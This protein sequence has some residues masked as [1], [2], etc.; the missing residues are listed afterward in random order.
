ML[1]DDIPNLF[2]N[3]ADSNETCTNDIPTVTDIP[4]SATNIPSFEDISTIPNVNA[5]SESSDSS[6]S[7]QPIMTFAYPNVADFSG[8]IPTQTA[9]RW[10][11]SI[12]IYDFPSPTSFLSFVDTKLTGS[13]AEWADENL[14]IHALLNKKNATQ[15]DKELFKERFLSRWQTTPPAILDN[16]QLQQWDGEPIV[17]FYKRV[18]AH[19]QQ[20]GAKDEINTVATGNTRANTYIL[21]Q[22]IHMF[23][24]GLK[25]VK[26][27]YELGKWAPRT[28][29]E[30]CQYAIRL[31]GWFAHTDINPR[32]REIQDTKPQRRE[33]Y[34]RNAQYSSYSQIPQS[35][36]ALTASDSPMP[37]RPC[38]FCGQKHWDRDCPRKPLPAAPSM[39]QVSTMPSS[40]LPPPINYPRTLQ[41]SQDARVSPGYA[42]SSRPNKTPNVSAIVNRYKDQNVLCFRCGEFGH[43]KDECAHPNPPAYMDIKPRIDAFIAEREARRKVREA[44]AASS[45]I[46]SSQV[47]ATPSRSITPFPPNDTYVPSA[48]LQVRNVTWAAPPVDPKAPAVDDDFFKRDPL[49]SLDIR[50]TVLTANA[51]SK[52]KGKIEKPGV[53]KSPRKVA[54]DKRA[55][56]EIVP[57]PPDDPQVQQESTT[58][59]A[60]PKN[61]ASDTPAKEVTSS[62]PGLQSN[63]PEVVMPD[64]TPTSN[65]SHKDLQTNPKPTHRR[66]SVSDPE[67][68]KG[69]AIATRRGRKPTLATIKGM[70]GKDKVDMADVLMTSN[71]NIPMLQFLQASPQ[72]RKEVSS[73]LTVPRSKRKSAKELFQTYDVTMHDP[74]LRTTTIHGSFFH[75]TFFRNSNFHWD[76]FRRVVYDYGADLNLVIPRTLEALKISKYSIKGTKYHSY[77]FKPVTG[78]PVELA[79]VVDI[80]MSVGGIETTTQFFVIPDRVAHT[81]NYSALLGLPHAYQVKGIFDVSSMTITMTDP[82]SGARVV[83]NGPHYKP[84]ERI[85][86][87]E[88][89]EADNTTDIESYYDG[90][91]D[92]VDEDEATEYD[93]VAESS[94]DIDEP[95]EEEE[96]HSDGNTILHARLCCVYEEEPPTFH[97]V[98]YYPLAQYTENFQDTEWA[99]VAQMLSDFQ[100]EWFDEETKTIEPCEI[101]FMVCSAPIEL[102]NHEGS[103]I[104]QPKGFPTE[105]RVQRR[106]EEDYEF[107]D[108]EYLLKW[109]EEVGVEI[110]KEVLQDDEWRLKILRLC[111]MWRNIGAESI[112]DMTIT[113]LVVVQPYFKGQP[114]PYACKFNKRLTPE[115]E[116]FFMDTIRKGLASGKYV[117]VF[118]EWNAPTVVAYKPAVMNLS[119]EVIA[120]MIKED[121]TKVFRLTHNYRFLNKQVVRPKSRL[122]LCTRVT[123]TLSHPR[124]IIYMLMDLK[125]AY[126]LFPIH[127]RYWH[128]FASTAPDGI[129]YAPT[130]MQQGFC[131]SPFHCAEGVAIA[132]GEIPPPDPE[133][134]LTGDNFRMYQDDGAGA[135]CTIQE[136]Y[137]F[138]HD[139]LFPRI[140]WAR[141]NV[142][143]HKVKLFM[144]RI[145]H[146]GLVFESGGI[147]HIDPARVEKITNYPVPQNASMVRSFVQACQICRPHIKN[148]SEM[149]RPL[150]RLTG[151]KVPFMW[152][153]NVENTSFNMLKSAVKEAVERHGFDNNLSTIL[154]ADG[155]DRCGGAVI[156]QVKPT[157]LEVVILYDS[158]VLSPA[159]ARY[160]T[161]KKELC[162]IIHMLKK[163][164]CYLGGI[165]PTIV[166]SDHQPLLGFQD[167][168]GR[169]AVEGI[170]ARW[171]EILEQSNVTWQ[172]LPGRKNRGA[173]A[174]SRTIFPDTLLER[175]I[176]DEDF[177]YH[178]RALQDTTEGPASNQVVLSRD[179]TTFNINDAEI[180][181]NDT[182]EAMQ[183]DVNS[184]QSLW[185]ALDPNVRDD[186]W[187]CD[188]I[189]Y[190]L[191][192]TVPENIRDIPSKSQAFKRQCR[193]FQIKD[194]HLY[195]KHKRGVVRCVSQKDVFD[196]L[197]K[198][199][200]FDGHYAIR[201][202]FARIGPVAWWPSRRDDIQQYVASCFECMSHGPV[203]KFE[204]L[205]PILTLQPFDM[206]GID[207]I[208]PL[209]KTP[210]GNV[211]VLHTIEYFSRASKAWATASAT[212]QVTVTLLTEFFSYYTKPI[213]VY[214]DNGTH[215]GRGVTKWLLDQGVVH[216]NSAS[217]TPKSTGMI[218]K[219]NHQLEE[220]I[221]RMAIHKP[222]EWDLHIDTATKDINHHP[223]ESL[224]FSPYEI[225]FGIHKRIPLDC[226]HAEI[227]EAIVKWSDCQEYYDNPK[228]IETAM[229]WRDETRDLVSE[230]DELR[231][232]KSKETYDAKLRGVP[233][234][235]E[236]GDLVMLYDPT[237]NASKFDI[238]WRGPFRIV[239]QVSISSYKIQHLRH[240]T[241]YPGTY[242]ADHL[243]IYMP[244]RED[245]RKESDQLVYKDVEDLPPP[246]LRARRAGRRGTAIAP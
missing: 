104:P 218:E 171:A 93:T 126:W 27:S 144:Y 196:V 102:N 91:E 202:T 175:D 208:G 34:S 178:A 110:G 241:P 142:A 167:S 246:T 234:K 238:S 145:K 123:D 129:Q 9:T 114:I 47:P 237:G 68:P 128:Y 231:V 243:K 217:Y 160:G 117:R 194:N 189:K 83:L 118:S 203:Y 18:L 216:L 185:D 1:L 226:F 71:I 52:K 95:S 40:V 132:F 48:P 229:A 108:E 111:Y 45:T 24:D 87:E 65:V 116:A 3:I 22:H 141:F 39:A 210:R 96:V 198:G 53:R 161:F 157:G 76:M 97:D 81:V 55:A 15:E 184:A 80:Q 152:R 158:F 134:A 103:E 139:H 20:V 193:W 242:N 124:Y 70:I 188:Q 221:R 72:A 67:T 79:H 147:I 130:V 17:E 60:E 204:P 227:A 192:G 172:Y 4:P 38:R 150:T 77:S 125:N 84:I 163:W 164:N 195:R 159:E 98:D 54:S 46:P 32:Y 74:T 240:A 136:L 162:V 33:Q 201:T 122:E 215:F 223:V 135:F 140:K 44:S 85:P 233:R 66:L 207:Y 153:E 120:A 90:S 56:E 220:R 133:P 107:P 177:E 94:D 6:T 35:P 112:A 82:I 86:L 245:W 14:E 25:D 19:L 31:E 73:L 63:A 43:Y 121:H 37:P 127:P 137:D 64:I 143:W 236:P 69:K 209:L 26:L 92:E 169:G 219:R 228:M 225:L 155:S 21:Q 131:V 58:I 113:D 5:D 16:V 166:K 205:H 235:Y 190:L 59:Q 13:A 57:P 199:H 41:S 156:K 183:I 181:A 213:A 105:R 206:I 244:R 174:M 100:W 106:S 191:F 179:D 28:L 148:F 42:P 182:A 50:S 224:G 165:R 214:A 176:K 168:A 115:A 232:I 151:T 99:T 29:E 154:E 88:L 119:P 200:D 149:A 212:E 146:L 36:L 89:K 170:Y 49:K 211:Y 239:E 109:V 62:V 23:M 2:I 75:E 180:A 101:G 186:P 187:Y 11:K 230:K 51:I 10:I 30:C 222:D 61:V 8:T 197:Q 78:P 138:L 173:D 12:D 7:K